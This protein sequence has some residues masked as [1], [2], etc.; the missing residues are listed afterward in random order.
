MARRGRNLEQSVAHACT[1][2]PD[3]QGTARGMRPV[4]KTENTSY[5]ACWSKCVH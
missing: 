5:D 4:Q 2:L 1:C 3:G